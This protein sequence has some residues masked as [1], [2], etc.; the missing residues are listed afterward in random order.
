MGI[1]AL[2][3]GGPRRAWQGATRSALSLQPTGG[4][5]QPVKPGFTFRLSRAALPLPASP[6]TAVASAF[7]NPSLGFG[8]SCCVSCC[9]CL[10]RPSWK[11]DG[12][13]KER[14][15]G[16]LQGPRF[17]LPAGPALAGPPYSPLG[18]PTQAFLNHVISG[19][20]EMA[21]FLSIL[22]C[23][24]LLTTLNVGRSTYFSPAEKPSG[25][26]EPGLDLRIL[27]SPRV[28]HHRPS[29]MKRVPRMCSISKSFFL[30]LLAGK[31]VC[32]LPYFHPV[33]LSEQIWTCDSSSLN[34]TSAI[35]TC[36]CLCPCVYF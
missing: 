30:P 6:S 25:R 5:C 28:P 18:P 15:W 13:F 9:L 4:L 27:L 1:W 12:G 33:S 23:Q 10:A 26:T 35:K 21:S 32:L 7:Q 14:G 22:R 17:L 3:H 36:D 8:N 16:R 31:D 20:G 11:R 19:P 2:P 24:A 34:M 29:Q